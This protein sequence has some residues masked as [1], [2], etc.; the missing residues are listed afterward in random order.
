MRQSSISILAFALMAG[1]VM[2]QDWAKAR[3]EKSPRHLE[4]VKVEYGGRVVDCF[5]ACPQ[6]KDPSTAVLVIHES[7]G[8]T[9]WVREVAD[10]LAE[11]G[12]IAIA[13]HL[14]S[15]AALIASGTPE[16]GGRDSVRKAID[17]LPSDQIT[18]DLKA[19]RDYLAKLLACKGKVAVAGFGWGGSQSFRYATNDEE[20]KAAF[21]FHGTAP[22]KVDELARIGCPVYGFYTSKDAP[23]TAII[24]KTAALIAQASQMFQPLVYGGPGGGAGHGFMHTGEAPDASEADTKLHDLAWT[25]WKAE[26]KKL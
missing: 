22:T 12:Y 19:A 8:L 7:L 4:W 9:D 16:P 17:S 10:Q 20:L 18:A 11:A 15:G 2:G 24:G 6:V 21:V 25:R 26:L 1:G 14:L 3:L 5:I 23:L 13:P